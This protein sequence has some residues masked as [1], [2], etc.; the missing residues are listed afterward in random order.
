[1]AP[2]AG[3]FVD[4][5]TGLYLPPPPG[6]AFDANTGV[7]MPPPTM[8]GIDP[9]TGGFMPPQGFMLDPIKGF[10]TV[11]AGAKEASARQQ[12][13]VNGPGGG[14][15]SSDGMPMGGR[16][17]EMGGMPMG[18]RPG[19]MGGMPMDGKPGEMGG[20][21]GGKPGEMGG[22]PMG[23]GMFGGMDP[24]MFGQMVGAPPPPGSQ[25]TFTSFTPGANQSASEYQMTGMGGGM[26]A[27]PPGAFMPGNQPFN[28]PG[29]TFGQ[30]TF[31]NYNPALCDYGCNAGTNTGNTAGAPPL[32]PP[33]TTTTISFTF[34]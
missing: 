2:P 13:M 23:G 26:N 17:G 8:G 15:M 27:P 28:L 9:K 6:S 16:P 14:P 1:M 11:A 32:P 19:E 22:M 5:M 31:T 21:P 12:E 30:Q 20:M 33:G 18:G 7:F 34:L 4:M 3:G 29:T 24:K 10:M 25:G